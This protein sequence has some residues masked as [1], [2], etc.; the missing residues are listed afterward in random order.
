MTDL[1]QFRTVP[2]NTTDLCGCEV[3][4]T[5]TNHAGIGWEVHN[6]FSF[7]FHRVKL[8]T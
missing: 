1:V 7:Y 5:T 8:T 6:S 3:H 2:S 4:K